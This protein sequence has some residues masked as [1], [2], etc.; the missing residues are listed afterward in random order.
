MLWDRNGS[1]AGWK[2]KVHSYPQYYWCP[3]VRIGRKQHGV[4]GPNG[5]IG[6]YTRSDAVKQA[7]LFLDR[8]QKI[9]AEHEKVNV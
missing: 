5:F 4:V 8:C 3:S 2:E 7:Q 6:Q 1:D 9:L